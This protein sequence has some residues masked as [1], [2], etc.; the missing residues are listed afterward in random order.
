MTILLDFATDLELDVEN[1]VSDFDRAW[2]AAQNTEF[3]ATDVVTPSTDG[4]SEWAIR[5]AEAHDALQ[6][7]DSCVPEWAL[8]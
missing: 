6:D 5:L 2:W 3:H 7:A 1:D 8:A 4:I